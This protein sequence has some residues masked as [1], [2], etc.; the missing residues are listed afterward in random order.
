M[1]GILINFLLN[2]T[3]CKYLTIILVLFYKTW[4]MDMICEN[5]VEKWVF[6]FWKYCSFRF[7]FHFSHL[8]SF[9]LALRK[10]LTL[11]L[12]F[13]HLSVIDRQT[14]VFSNKNKCSKFCLQIVNNTPQL[15]HFII[16]LIYIGKK[17]NR[18]SKQERQPS[19]Y[20][21]TCP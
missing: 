5:K 10:F 15:S 16:C 3:T 6:W 18:R 17:G 11:Q 21:L 2:Q 7:F 9:Y 14:N 1:Q 8:C 19:N 4:K 20:L 13:G 12:F